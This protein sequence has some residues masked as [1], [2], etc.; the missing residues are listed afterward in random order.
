MVSR[1][2][3][4]LPADELARR[5]HGRRPADVFALLARNAPRCLPLD[6]PDTV[7]AETLRRLRAELRPVPHA[8]HALTWILRAQGSRLIIADRSRPAEPRSHG[9]VAVLNRDCSRR[10]KRPEANRRRIFFC[11]PPNASVSIRLRASWL[12]I[13]SPVLLP[14]RPR[15]CGRLVSSVA[16]LRRGSRR[17]PDRCWRPRRDRRSAC[18]QGRRVE[19]RVVGR[20]CLRSIRA[21]SRLRLRFQPFLCRR[22]RLGP[23]LGALWVK[24]DIDDIVV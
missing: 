3:V 4:S 13:R 16:V 18:A 21:G 12:R 9:P 7:A 8:A 17:R 5:F 6:F 24:T 10:A 11:R 20:L 19:L 23:R 14:P 22:R 15:A 2:G 1:I